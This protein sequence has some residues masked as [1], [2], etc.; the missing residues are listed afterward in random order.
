MTLPCAIYYD[1]LPVR[2]KDHVE[3]VIPFSAEIFSSRNFSDSFIITAG[4]PALSHMIAES[5]KPK[6]EQ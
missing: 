6:L 1:R 5:G 4:Q 3:H 2:Y